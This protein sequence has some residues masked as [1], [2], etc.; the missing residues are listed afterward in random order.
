MPV[1]EMSM[2]T[3]IQAVKLAA[4]F[5]NMGLAELPLVKLIVG[6]RM[7]QSE[8]K[9]VTALDG[10]TRVA[11]LTKAPPNEAR[12]IYGSILGEFLDALKDEIEDA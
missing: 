11:M 10:L 7:F 2:M 3:D 5:T 9:N 6:S 12:K 8:I 1:A 4:N